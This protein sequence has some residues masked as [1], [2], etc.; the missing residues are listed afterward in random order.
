MKTTF[1]RHNIENCE[2]E[3]I[4][5]PESIQ[6][7]GYLLAAHP[8]KAIIKAHSENARELFGDQLIGKDLSELLGKERP[9]K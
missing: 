5:I 8:E 3:P 1:G 9:H 7:Y 6:S 2:D 4:H